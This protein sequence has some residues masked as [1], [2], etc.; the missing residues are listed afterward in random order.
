MDAGEFITIE[1]MAEAVGL[2]ERHVS[3]QLRMAHLTP[4]V[5]K[6]LI[7]GLESSVVS[8]YDLSFLTGGTWGDQ[9]G[10]TFGK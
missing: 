4:K 2:A 8:L 1:E 5:L 9:L 6:R 3:R 7:W 10:R